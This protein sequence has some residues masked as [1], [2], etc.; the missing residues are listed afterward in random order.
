M[1]YLIS[2][3]LVNIAAREEESVRLE[4]RVA[5]MEIFFRQMM[6]KMSSEERQRLIDGV[7]DKVA[8]NDSGP[9]SYDTALLQQQMNRLLD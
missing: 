6:D 3:L 7:R 1:R 4:H 2:E 5:V 9:V 8:H